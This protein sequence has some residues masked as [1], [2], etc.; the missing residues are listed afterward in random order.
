MANH[1]LPIPFLDLRKINISYQEEFKNIFSEFLDSGVYLKGSFLQRFEIEYA[2]YCGT[3]YCVG[4]GNG[5]DALT[6]ILRA[7]IEL[8]RLEE[9]DEVIVAANTFI[10]TI[11]SIKQAGLVPVLVEPDEKTFN[12][13]I[14]N[15]KTSVSSKTKVIIPTHLYGQLA[16]IPEINSFA[17]EKGFLVIADAAQAHGA[18]DKGGNKAG[19]LCDAA[20]FSFYPAKNM[21]ALGDGGAVTTNDKDVADMVRSLG[22]YGTSTKYINDFIGVNSRL[23]EIQ[24]GFLLAKLKNLEKDNIK[25]RQIAESYLSEINNHKILL[26]FWNKTNNHVFH[27]FVVR[28]KDRKHFVNYLEK[29]GIGYLIHYPVPPH[30]QKALIEF[31]YLSLPITE[32]IHE[33]VVSIPLHIGLTEEEIKQIIKILNAY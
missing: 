8:G 30:R 16:P 23:D 33:E 2:K 9:G 27:L 25:R 3:G 10:A 20:A 29:S 22:N 5:L 11:L 19:N 6:L 4:T 14:P 15:I 26:P 24:A 18:E 31:S 13:N 7:Y 28:V 17:Q 12:I 1:Q 21:G 32:R